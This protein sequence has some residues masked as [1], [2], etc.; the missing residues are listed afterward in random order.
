MLNLI[1]ELLG[2]E[3]SQTAL[4]PFVAGFSVYWLSFLVILK[5][6]QLAVISVSFFRKSW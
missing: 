3:L 2:G 1:E 6:L 4:Y 5:T